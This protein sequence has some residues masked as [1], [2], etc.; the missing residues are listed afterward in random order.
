VDFNLHIPANALLLAVILGLVA[1]A[2]HLRH[3]H[4][5][6]T[7]VFQVR[8][9]RPPRPLRLALY[10]LAVLAA[11]ALALP[12]VK[13]FA[14]HRHAQLAEGLEREPKEVDVTEFDRV[15][16]EWEYAMAL[17]PGNADYRNRLGQAYDW[18]MQA[19]SSREPFR[20]FAA[21]LQAMAAYREAILRNPTA[22]SPYLAWGWT[23]ENVSGLAAEAAGQRAPMDDAGGNGLVHLITEF[24][25]HPERAA[26][27]GRH[28]MQTATHL[29][30]TNA[31]AHYSAGLY[32]LQQWEALGSEERAR[33]VH[34]LRSAIQLEPGYAPVILEPLW[35]R[36]RDRDVVWTVARGTP[37]ES[38]WR[39][40]DMTA[41]PAR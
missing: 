11:L 3:R 39:N 35:Q 33:V 27:W 32:G 1:V 38:Q 16:E 14:A 15:L 40:P 22:P 7:V 12:V 29:S 41:A 24:A 26:Q 10:P 23:L 4:G 9:L 2:V 30:P 8:E 17:D 36:T 18:A 21:G 28:L 31:A 6:S 37:A 13:S 20:A 19:Q 34:D 5:D 25:Q